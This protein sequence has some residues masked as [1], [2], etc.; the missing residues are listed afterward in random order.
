MVMQTFFYAGEAGGVKKG[1]LWPKMVDSLTY[2][3]KSWR[4][5]APK[6][7]NSMP[8]SY[9]T[10]RFFTAFRNSIRKLDLSGVL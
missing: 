1:A 7:W 8:N 10:I 6:L 3:L 5:T 9:R 2:G 4:F